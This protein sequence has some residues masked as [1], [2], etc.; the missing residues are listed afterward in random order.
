MTMISNK[1]ISNK[2]KS[3]QYV[4]GMDWLSGELEEFELSNYRKYQYD[5]IAKH[6]GKNILEIGSGDRSF[7]NQVRKYA[8]QFDRLI[9]IEPSVTLFE[10]HK[11]KYKFPNHVSFYMLDLFNISKDTFGQFDTALLVHVLE[12]IEK[13]REALNKVHELLL[14]NGKVLIEVPAM[15]FLFSVHDELLGHYRRYDK[16]TLKD[17]VDTDK[18]V[19]KNIWYQDIIGVFGSLVFFKIKKTKLASNN[20]VQ[21]I[22]NQGKVYDKYVIPFETF[23]E[24]YMRF[25]L[26]LSLTAVLQKK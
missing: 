26:G 11:D 9:S 19:I 3:D 4:H 16:R 15:P 22:K 12:H 7:T 21:L 23:I 2:K 18:Y 1:N 24:K 14:P 8:G 6:L 13:D 17:I 20:G 10:T 5:L 25:P